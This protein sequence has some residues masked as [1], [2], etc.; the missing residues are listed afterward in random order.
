MKR[1][2]V[3]AC[4]LSMLSTRTFAQ[5]PGSF[6]NVIPVSTVSP[7][8]A[9]L[10]KF[11]NIPVSYATGV[12]SVNIPIYEINVGGIKIPLSLDYHGGGVRVD[13]VSSSV[14]TSW[15]LSGI[16]IL[17]R[18]MIGLA[19]ESG[20]TGYLYSP[21]PDSLV[22]YYAGAGSYGATIDNGYAQFIYDVRDNKRETEPDVFSY[23]LNGSSG[24]FIYRRDGTTMQIPVTNNRIERISGNNFKITDENGMV[25]IFDQQE[26]T[27]MVS[28]SATG[29]GTYV[30]SWRLSKMVAPN[31]VD[32][33]YY[34]YAGVVG[35]TEHFWNFT[36]TFGSNPTYENYSL[37]MRDATGENSSVTTTAH[38]WQLYPTQIDWRG[39][40][41]VF[42]N[43]SDRL[44]R[45]SDLRLD[46]V[47]VY[48]K[49]SGAYQL[50]KSIK[51]FQSYFYSNPT[52]LTTPDYRNYRLRLDS[53]AFVPVAGNLPSQKYTMVYNTSPIAPNESFAQ[54][55]WGYNNGQYTNASLMPRQSILW[56]GIY[57][58]IGEANMDPDT[59]GTSMQACMLQSITY[60]TKGKSVFT[61]EPH[62]Y[63]LNYQSTVQHSIGC[64]AYGS[65]Q[66][67]D[68][69]RFTVTSTQSNFAYLATLTAY[70]YPDVT[71]RPQITMIDQ[72]TGQTIFIVNNV[73]NPSQAY[74]TGTLALSLTT[75][76]TY[77]IVTNIYTTNPN[78]S[79]TCHVSW[80]EPIS[81]IAIRKGGGLRVSSIINYDNN[82]N[83]INKER[84][85]YGD[86]GTGL[87]L[88]PANYLLLNYETTFFQL[89]YST[90]QSGNQNGFG[91]LLFAISP[92]AA[93]YH[94]KSIYPATQFSGSPVVYS[95][96]TKYDMDN[97]G[98]VNGKSV[99]SYNTFQDQVNTLPSDFSDPS[100]RAYFKADSTSIGIWLIGN[101]WK[102]GFMNKESTYRS[103]GST[104]T[105]VHIK[106]Y[107]YQVYRPETI[108][109]VKIKPLYIKQ[110]T[111]ETV[112]DT[113]NTK[114][115]L[116]GNI[117][118]KLHF[119]IG[120]V[121]AST[122]AML[123]Q[124]ESD[125]TFDSSGNKV[126]AVHNNYYDDLTHTLPTRKE[127]FN[128]KGEDMV[129]F[130]KYPHDLAVTGNVYQTMLNRNIVSPT[131]RFIQRKNTMQVDSTNVNYYDWN[132]NG[133]LLLEKSVDAN[134]LSNPMERR[135]NLDKYD[136]Y[137][138]I[139]QQEKAKAPNMSYQWGYYSQYPVAK[140]ANAP[141]N[142][143]FYDSFE[144]GNGTSTLNDS[145]T[146][147]YSF[148]GSYSKTL[149][150]L[151]TGKYILSYWSKAAGVWVLNFNNN[152]H[153]TGNSY[154]IILSGPIDDVRFYPATAQMSTYTYDPQIGMTSATDVKGE[155]TYYEYDGFQR[156]ITIRDKDKNVLK[157]FDYHYQ[158]STFIPK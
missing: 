137:G 85:Q 22:N 54:D 49:V 116:A 158:T 65:V 6:Q 18:N 62:S 1:L 23:T 45:P 33:I 95:S 9:S 117:G 152:I 93:I 57:N 97:S 27:Q 83:F 50:V 30:S 72:N 61:F 104:Y 151:D 10:G 37:T 154:S 135:L 59:L 67:T 76:H 145:K 51:L 147:H 88:T 69:T 39:G 121:P 79:A 75:G 114:F 122:G 100:Y 124:S 64:D 129:D 74:N 91:A 29:P 109:C 71:N 119:F 4:I 115:N 5:A 16:G 38:V 111:Y 7:E 12:P 70:N 113:F 87:L 53:V 125:T 46:S 66:L 150:G 47:K 25:Y 73:S 96:V 36:Y 78:V 94:Q 20:G 80:T 148:S 84:Y 35:S 90:E 138:N 52:N 15:A 55:I 103:N 26:Q 157:H 21:S 68:T 34:T 77:Q 139:L 58:P 107:N 99:Y 17:S 89:G 106:Q 2:L 3:V 48:S 127:T 156:L 133:T 92:T 81:G 140:V 130:I 146:G 128:S 118:G 153:V 28:A 143:I 14:G 141:V 8:A 82:G 13:E 123:L 102:N 86:Y 126:V 144:E 41:I 60:P 142:D 42:K 101:D 134:T 132:G 155:V 108:Q 98:N 32:T 11:G 63:P 56:N 131:V 112:P 44:D 120:K 19:D 110:G 149:T 136:Q 105:P 24:K 43:A 31:S 40:R